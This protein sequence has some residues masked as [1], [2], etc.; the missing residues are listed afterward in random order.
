MASARSRDAMLNSLD[1]LTSIFDEKL[2]DKK[3]YEKAQQIIEL[4]NSIDDAKKHDLKSYDKIQRI[5]AKCDKIDDKNVKKTIKLINKIGKVKYNKKTKKKI[6]AAG[7][8]YYA[9]DRKSVV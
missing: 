7:K 3:Y 4:F 9:L 1:M 8:S 6:L 2:P 5:L